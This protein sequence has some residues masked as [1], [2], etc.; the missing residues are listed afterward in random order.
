MMQLSIQAG[1]QP[2]PTDTAATK[3]PLFT[4]FVPTYNRRILLPRLLESVEAQTFTDFEL[5]IVDDGS[6][7]GSF[8]YLCQYHQQARF[9]MRI[10]YQENQGRHIA[11]NTAF[12]AASGLLFTTIN[13]D[14][15][16]TPNALKR[17]AHWW[18]KSQESNATPPIVGVEGL[19]A[20]LETGKIIGTP[21]P[22]SPMVADH[23]EVYFKRR[24]WGD[25]MRAIRTDIIRQYRFPKIT[26]ERYLPP[27][28][29]WDRLGF[30]KHRTLY[31]NEILCY[32][33][34]RPDGVTRNRVRIRAQNAQGVEF[35][36]RDFLRQAYKDGRVPL[37]HLI[38][39]T[40]NWVRYSL[41]VRSFRQ[42]LQQTYRSSKFPVWMFGAPLGILLHMNDRRLLKHR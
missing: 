26:G 10:I 38:R 9:P 19:C 12:E 1:T 5:L 20:S 7:D 4:L 36:F 2:T 22:E 35:Y 23:I 32:K 15:V 41:Y 40:A 18:Q 6:Q 33:E 8:D 11:F 14:D 13:S 25:T 37:P 29:L 42:T 17:L 28:Y 21:F 3:Q 24:C 27:S 39:Y 16:L 30:N 34:Y 31:F